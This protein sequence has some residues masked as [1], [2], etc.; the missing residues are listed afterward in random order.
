MMTGHC[1]NES[2]K[3]NRPVPLFEGL[4]KWCYNRKGKG[5]K[6]LDPV[7]KE[8]LK[9]AA[10]NRAYRLTAAA[11][12][13][14][15]PICEAHLPGCTKVTE[16]VHHVAGRVGANMLDEAKF[17]AVCRACHRII[18]ENPVMAKALGLSISRLNKTDEQ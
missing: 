10:V 8:S 13:A 2:C 12:K 14:D 17:L 11:F 9:Q 3:L 7:K 15:H 1:A 6:V 16:D 5:K 18:E 4:C